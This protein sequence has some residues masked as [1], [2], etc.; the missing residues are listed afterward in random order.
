[1][2]YNAE[3]L[4]KIYLKEI[5]R[6]HGVPIFIISNRGIQFTSIFGRSCMRSCVQGWTIVQ[7]SPSD[8]W[9]VQEYDLSVRGYAS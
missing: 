5:V 1:M 7:L 8:R 6:L 4:A 9:A 3:K 2:T